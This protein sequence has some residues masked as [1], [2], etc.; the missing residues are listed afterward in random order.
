MKL[1]LHRPAEGLVPAE[2]DGE[3]PECDDGVGH[4]DAAAHGPLGRRLRRRRDGGL[5]LHHLAYANA[6][7]PSALST[8]NA[9]PVAVD[10]LSP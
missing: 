5:D 4:H 6:T 9:R 2:G 3:V 10:A 7:A 8:P 1:R